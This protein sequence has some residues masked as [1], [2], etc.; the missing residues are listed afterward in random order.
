MQLLE[1]GAVK[2]GWSCALGDGQRPFSQSLCMVG[3]QKHFVL[4]NDFFFFFLALD[5]VK[6]CPM[7]TR[8]TSRVPG[9]SLWGG[10]VNILLVKLLFSSLKSPY[11]A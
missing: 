9:K 11:C 4:S 7:K 2:V 1:V 10:P 6:M 8:F 5:G 3:E